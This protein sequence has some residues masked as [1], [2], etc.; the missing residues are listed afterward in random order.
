MVGDFVVCDENYPPTF[1]RAMAGSVFWSRNYGLWIVVMLVR[2]KVSRAAAE[3]ASFLP[4][5]KITSIFTK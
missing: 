4:S 3:A 5:S 1:C 2:V